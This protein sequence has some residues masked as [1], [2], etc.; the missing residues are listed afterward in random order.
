[1]KNE[2]LN[3]TIDSKNIKNSN[4]CFDCIANETE[5]DMLIVDIFI[6]S[7]ANLIASNKKCELMTNFFACCS[8]LC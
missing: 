3:E 8:R 1:M 6:D 4:I 2:L 7:L 5:N